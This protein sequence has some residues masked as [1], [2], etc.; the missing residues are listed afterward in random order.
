MPIIIIPAQVDDQTKA[1]NDIERQLKFL[2]T[3]A[4]S[5]MKNYVNYVNNHVLNNANIDSQTIMDS[6][7]IDGRELLGILDVFTSAVNTMVPDTV[8]P[9]DTTAIAINVDGTVTLP[10]AVV[11]T[12]EPTIPVVEG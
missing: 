10:V 4:Y 3:Q 2:A 1:I 8:V 11:E 5:S 7:G 9:I 12:P 6:I